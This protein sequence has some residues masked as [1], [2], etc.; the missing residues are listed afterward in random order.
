MGNDVTVLLVNDEAPAAEETASILKNHGYEVISVHSPEEAIQKIE[1]T[2]AQLILMDIDLG[3]GK[4]DGIETAAALLEK[5]DLPVVFISGHSE[6]EYLERIKTV[7]YYGFIHKGCSEFL[8]TETVD[9]AFELF[10][11]QQQLKMRE[12]EAREIV[13]NIENAI[14]RYDAGGRISYFSSGAERMF[15]F[16]AE[17]VVGTTGLGAI[18][19]DIDTTGLDHRDML[20]DIINHPEKYGYNENENACKNG[21]R[22]WIAWRNKAVYDERGSLLY[23]Q[24]IGT[25]I[26]DHKRVE[27]ELQQSVAEKDYLMKEL[28]HRVKNNLAIISSLIRLKDSALGPE[29]DL[30]DIMHQIDAVRIVHE[31]LY[32]TDDITQIN[33]KDYLDDLLASVFRSFTL[34]PV[35]IENRIKDI[36]LTTKK[37]IP[38][39]LI[40]NELATNAI[41][42]GFTGEGEAVFTVDLRNEP[43]AGYIFTVSNNGAPFPREIDPE[44]SGTLGLRLVSALAG[45]LEGSLELQREPHPT[46]TFRFP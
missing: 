27:E 12:L 18:N 9:R 5:R 42:H 24:S 1:A 38:L 40:T 45:Q 15:G 34:K 28:N 25:D 41:K 13:D 33:V 6:K 43:E 32:R 29:V 37:T 16:P 36:K 3:K 11:Y 35:K 44:H 46:F 19:P 26:T 17:E 22:L 23:I 14:L 21:S 2:P 4:P 7:A 8:L 31:K 30:S 10:H 20:K 39:G